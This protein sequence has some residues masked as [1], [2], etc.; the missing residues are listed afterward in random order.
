MAD[1]L[2][3]QAAVLTAAFSHAPAAPVPITPVP[4]P[5]APAVPPG[6]A[7]VIE[8]HSNRVLSPEAVTMAG[9]I[10]EDLAAQKMTQ[11]QADKAFD[12]LGIPLD[13]RVTPADT[14]TDEHK[15][16][17]QH[18]PVAKPEEFSIRYANPGQAWPEMTP[19]MKQFDQSARTWL[20]GA[21][22]SRDLGNSLISTIEKT[23]QHTKA[24]T[25]AQLDSYAMVEH[26]KLKRIYG[27]TLNEKL[28][29]A[30]DMIDQIEDQQAGLK[31]LLG[32][33]GIGRNAL[34]WNM[35]IGQAERYWIRRK[36]R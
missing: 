8:P 7:P 28:H 10:K 4:A 25:P 32:S 17:D 13:Q 15:L 34:I 35:L 16:I 18:F 19:E 5:T 6:S 12:E 22:F 24:M 3:P 11:A 20:S 27:D 33:V 14:R 2:T 30:D 1:N 29:A 26:D 23:V 31:N 36:G 9:W 21:E